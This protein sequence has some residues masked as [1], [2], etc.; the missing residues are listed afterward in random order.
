MAAD[1]ETVIVEE[2]VE[3]KPA[4]TKRIMVLRVD[5]ETKEVLEAKSQLWGYVAVYTVLLIALW[6]IFRS[7][8]FL[9]EF[10]EP[11]TQIYHGECDDGRGLGMFAIP[12]VITAVLMIPAFNSRDIRRRMKALLLKQAGWDG[13]H[14]YR[15]E[16]REDEAKD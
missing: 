5:S 12:I 3:A 14:E 1:F 15:L 4:K 10:S 2:A 7:F 13:R 11:C 16:V 8:D 6:V 9:G